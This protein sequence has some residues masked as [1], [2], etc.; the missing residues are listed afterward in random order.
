MNLVAILIITSISLAKVLATD[1]RQCL[2]SLGNV[3]IAHLKCA[4]EVYSCLH[5]PDKAKVKVIR[6]ECNS[7]NGI[8]QMDWKDLGAFTNVTTIEM[9]SLQLHRVNVLFTNKSNSIT[10]LKAS[11]NSFSVI[12]NAIFKMAP[13]VVEID[14]SYN[15]LTKIRVNDF[16][17]ANKIS[18]MNCSHN[19]II[20]LS[21]R[22][23]AYLQV[24]ETLDL[25]GNLI[26]AIEPDTFVNN[27]NLKQLDLR[28]NPLKMFDFNVLPK[29]VDVRLPLESIEALNVSCPTHSHTICQFDGFKEGDFFPNLRL[30]NA[31][32]SGVN[33]FQ[34]LAPL[35]TTLEVLDLSSTFVGAI[36]SNMFQKFVHLN[37]LRLSDASISSIETNALANHTE[38]KSLDLSRNELLKVNATTF[39]STL[40]TMHFEYNN[41][42]RIDGIV[43]ETFPNLTALVISGNQFT[44]ET[45][46]TFFDGWKNATDIQFASVQL[47]YQTNINGVE[48]KCGV[49]TVYLTES[50]STMPYVISV[51]VL[52]AVSLSLA[53][54]VIICVVKNC[55]QKDVS[56]GLIRANAEAQTGDAIDSGIGD[57]S[58]YEEIE[59]N[60]IT[61]QSDVFDIQNR[62]LPTPNDQ[63]YAQIGNV[64][65]STQYLYAHVCKRDFS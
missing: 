38:L 59:L 9:S 35:G 36:T 17:G 37:E 14:F 42:V 31:S 22:T 23:F 25:R 8:L 10:T 45:L 44:C 60:N 19:Q 63:H 51:A 64:T 39:P 12:P 21:R 62:P 50:I 6:Y 40:Q 1:F 16:I 58:L 52:S 57:G 49:T 28:D 26:A 20:S 7:F 53:A 48:C 61:F 27:S 11:N 56:A 5:I 15:N 34:L 41:L 32:K 29:P 4:R 55:G 18:S 54:V 46:R 2:V 24:L 3:E 33:I 65:P 30:F 43:R 47:S 13:N